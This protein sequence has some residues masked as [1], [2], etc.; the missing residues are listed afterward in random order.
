LAGDGFGS[1]TNVKFIGRAGNTLVDGSC[2]Q[3]VQDRNNNAKLDPCLQ[4][5]SNMHDRADTIGSTLAWNGLWRH[6]LDLS[7][8]VIFTRAQTDIDVNGASYANN[9]FALAG[10]PVLPAGSP[11]VFLIPAAN[12][13]PV[14][15]RTFELRLS[16]RY[17]LTPSSD[18]R[19][20]YEYART[21]IEDFAYEGLQPGTGTEQMPTLEQ[22]PNYVVQVVAL[23]YRHRF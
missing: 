12:L 1:N 20:M 10:A 23:Y 21:K 14:V 8:D 22:A 11:A 18:L 19:L 3:T 2:Y 5:S 17:A 16:G 7:G 13:P 9:P 15:T 4:W 6:R